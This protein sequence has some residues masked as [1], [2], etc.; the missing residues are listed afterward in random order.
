MKKNKEIK[1]GEKYYYY[2]VLKEVEKQGRQTADR[3]LCQCECG[4]NF[5]LTARQIKTGSKKSCGCKAKI[6]FKEYN[7]KMSEKNKIPVG[8]RFGKLT[9]IED[10]GYKQLQ[11]SGHK[12]RTYRCRCDC[13]NEII[14]YGNRLKNG[15]MSCGHCLI[16]KGEYYIKE[17]LKE[18]DIL[19]L[20]DYLFKDIKKR[21]WT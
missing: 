2:T 9:V 7:K 19:F 1:I 15:A 13:G 14:T 6:C 18:N 4:N 17:L 16:S 5:I 10:L 12:R 8:T 20:H 21:N 11:E 3:Y